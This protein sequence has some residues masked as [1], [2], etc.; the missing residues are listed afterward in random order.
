MAITEQ[1]MKAFKIYR[2]RFTSALHISNPHKEL[3]TSMPTIQSDALCATLTACLAKYGETVGADFD[4]GCMVSSLFP[5]YQK[6]DDAA[7]VYF[8]PRPMQT[9]MPDAAQEDLKKL[10]KIQWVDAA[11]YA[12]VLAGRDV[13]ADGN[14]TLQGVYYTAQS[15]PTSSDG[16]SQFICS[17]V[18]QRV[19][20]QSR[21]G[22]KDAEPY[23]VDRIVF[24]DKA[25]LYFIA[26]GDTTKLD[27][28][29]HYLSLEGIGTYRN[30]GFGQFGYEAGKLEIQLP[31]HADH[32]ISLSMFIP[33]SKEQLRQLLD[34][35]RVAYDFVRRGGW[36]TT[37]PYSTLR[38][39]AIYA[40][41]PGSVFHAETQGAVC[42]GKRV[43]LAPSIG[44]LTPDHPVWR[45]GRA[46]MLPIVI[47]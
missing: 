24:R 36:I 17:E 42:L 10:K 4:M 5:Y 3:D 21:T 11:L 7:P 38:K 45:E 32:L 22:E 44:E 29:L 40:F 9:K 31:D 12:D 37:P 41:M 39:N 15:L 2:L 35:D 27:K 14:G 46:L 26:E 33:E 28:A 43:N 8:L 47:K 25:G 1:S 18:M 30:V 16:S 13:L 34:S 20:L 19:T 6:A 23:Y